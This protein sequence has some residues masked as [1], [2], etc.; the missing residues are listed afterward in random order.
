[1]TRTWTATDACSNSATASQTI[2]VIDTTPPVIA[3]LPAPTT[4]ECPAVPVFAVASAIDACGSTFTLTSA[5]VTTPGCGG[6]YSVTRTWTATDAC[7]NSSTANQTITVVDTTHPTIQCP[8]N[9]TVGC[10]TELLVPVTFPAPQASDTCGTVTVISSPA[11]G[12]SFPIGVTT[13]TNTATDACGNTT[14]CYFTVT[15][16][17]LGFTGFLPPIGGADATGGSFTDPLQAF[18]LGSTIP[19]KFQ[20]FCGGSPVVTGIHTLQAI[21]YS[22]MTTAET[23]ID[24]T[25][26]DAATTG[27]QFRLT[28]SEWHFN[29]STKSG[30]SKGIWKLVVTLSDGSQHEVWIEIKK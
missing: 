5:D 1:V 26:T 3:T 17:G 23:A 2:N 21:K 13:V 7:G 12:S 20:A 10:S 16:A 24:A 29:L 4:I 15:R 25:P 14:T 6:A 28:D 19:I 11:S 22:S 9:V 27:N 30:F 18:K 8:P